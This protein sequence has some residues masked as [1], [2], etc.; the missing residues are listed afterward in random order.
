MASAVIELTDVEKVY[1]TGDVALRAL[2]GVSL[3]VDEGEFVAVMG[4]SGSGKSTLMNIV[5]CLD[6][7]TA[8]SYMLAGKQVAGMSRS[9]L[10][11]IRNKV[12]GFVFQQFNLLSRTTALENV[13]LPLVYGGF[14]SRERHRRA[15]EALER[16]GLGQRMHH[17]PN[18]LSGGQQQRVAIARAIVNTP[19][20]ILADEPTGA[21]D[22]RTSV[23]VMA[24][25]QGLWRSGITVVL[26]THEPDVAAVRLAGRA[27]ERRTRPVGRRDQDAEA[28]RSRERRMNP[29]HTLRVALR[30]ILRNK[31]RAFL[32]TL[33][34]VIGVGAVIAMM[35][36]GAGAKA[37]VEQAFAAMGTNVLIV[38]PGSTST[39]GVHGG[40]GSMPT[41]TWDDLGRDPHRGPHRTRGRALAP[42]EPARRE[43]GPE[44]DHQHLR[45]VAGVLRHPQLARGPGLRPHAERHRRRDQGHRARGRPSRQ[46][47]TGTT[48][49]PSA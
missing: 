5:G 35:A 1:Q 48:P 8:G 47:S 6:R 28:S 4:S 19:K 44:L 7:P 22:S 23:D 37:Q 29:F 26:V 36:I 16:V 32:T 42:L 33:G 3:R 25:F 14:G 45:D 20:V 13:E 12:L 2:D 39:S 34:I 49:I 43:R 9:A 10:A 21:L 30:A 40:F 17:H 31:L 11:K 27:D 38:L 24:L 41:L 46:S 18:Q 15:T